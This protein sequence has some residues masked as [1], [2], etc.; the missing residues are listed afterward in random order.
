MKKTEKEGL[1][2]YEKLSTKEEII[3]FFLIYAFIGWCL[4]TLYAYMVFGHFVKRGFLYGPICPIYGFGAVLLLINLKNINKDNNIAKF[5]VSMVSFSIFEYIASFI[6]EI[7]FHKRWWDYTGFFLNIQGRICLVFAIIW[8][9]IGVIFINKIHPWVK[10]R[11]TKI[12]IHLSIYARKF[13]ILILFLAFI[14][15]EIFSVIKYIK[16]I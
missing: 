3:I 11:V 7:I 6:L 12:S 1:I 9:I 16:G 13:I 10:N 15:D 14:I 8:G 5:L 4:E 2:K